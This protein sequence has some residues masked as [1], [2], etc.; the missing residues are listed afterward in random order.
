MLKHSPEFVVRMA[1]TPDDVA[2]AQRL[3]YA[4]FVE[5]LGADGKLVDH[6]ARRE[7]DAFDPFAMHLLLE[8]VHPHAPARLIGAYRLMDR[9]C[10]AKAGRFYS[11]TEFDLTALRNSNRRILELGR[12]CVHADY[13][14]GMA[15]HRIWSGLAAFVLDKKYQILFGVAS[16]Y[17][18]DLGPLAQPLSYLQANHL[19]SPDLAPV[20]RP[21]GAVAM[22]LL[23]AEAI[24]R[25]AAMVATP[26]LIK[27]YLR[28][29]GSVGQGA[30]VD[31]DFQTTDVCLVLDT[32]EMDP[33][34]RKLY[35]AGGLQ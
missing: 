31:H 10:A 11:E 7:A 21:S 2:A 12:A 9:D 14:G 3:R 17:G 16:F 5:E 15:M 35:S 4:V 28:L 26:A 29:G 27:A 18:T 30:F 22:D 8:D 19:A 20:A 23:P 25:K 6:V 1:A 34:S 24:D 33:Q 13:R 32:A